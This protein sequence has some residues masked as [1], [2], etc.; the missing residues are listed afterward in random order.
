[1]SAWTRAAL[2]TVV[3]VSAIYLWLGLHPPAAREP[4]GRD[5]WI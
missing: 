5:W 2:G 1:M 4:V 3:A